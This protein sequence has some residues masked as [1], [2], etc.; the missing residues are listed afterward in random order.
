[1]LFKRKTV[2]E[3]LTSS[4]RLRKYTFC[5]LTLCSA[6]V[7]HASLAD[8]S[9]CTLTSGYGFNSQ[10]VIPVLGTGLSTVGED[11][12]VGSVIY[13]S[14][15]NVTYGLNNALKYTCPDLEEIIRITT[16]RKLEVINQ[17]VGAPVTSGNDAIYPT[18]VPGIGVK[19]SVRSY[20]S[21][22]TIFPHYEEYETLI[23]DGLTFSAQVFQSIT[24]ELIKTGPI[25]RAVTQQVQASSFPTFQIIFGIK[26]PDPREE[27]MHTIRFVGELTLH[28]RTCQLVTPEINVELGSHWATQFKDTSPWENFD[29]TLKDCPPFYGYG[30]YDGKFGVLSGGSIRD[31]IIDIK[32]NSAYGAVEGYPFLAKL[33]N[34]TDSAEGI[35]IELSLRDENNSIAMDGSGGF[36]LKNLIIE[37]N[38][39]IRIPLRARYV[40]YESRLK[41]GKA[42]S[43]VIF[44]ITYQ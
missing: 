41:P 24:F 15:N 2:N 37:G 4:A 17:P 11:L 30:S 5:F 34:G 32:F 3:S 14:N 44:T 12:P 27:I 31:N 28:T 6:I 38:P 39:L 1:M 42:N 9:T 23:S 18:N 8:M 20:R 21:T 13:T 26:D 40:Q 43:A 22:P 10:D 19:F 29:I 33:E 36:S 7:S 16:Y 35:G 25:D